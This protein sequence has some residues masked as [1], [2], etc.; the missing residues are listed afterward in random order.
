MKYLAIILFAFALNLSVLNASFFSNQ[1][2]TS[3]PLSIELNVEKMDV[4]EASDSYDDPYFY[5]I[6]SAYIPL[7]ISNTHL[8]FSAF[9]PY[10]KIFILL[11]PPESN[12]FV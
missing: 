2:E 8:S 3:A 12:L 7:D 4:S 1:V 11:E 9:Y 10:E 5:L 6:S